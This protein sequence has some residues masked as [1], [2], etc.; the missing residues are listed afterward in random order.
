MAAQGPF[1]WTHRVTYAE[2]TVGNHVYYG[3]YLEWLE[4][5]RGE[6]LRQIGL[7]LAA[8]QAQDL[9]FPVVECRLRYLAPAR[10]DEDVHVQVT[11]TELDRLR[12]S[13]AYQVVKADGTSVLEGATRHVCTSS[14]EKPRRLPEEI[15]Q[16][17]AAHLE[18]TPE[19][20]TRD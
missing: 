4:A 20:E 6:F 11:L 12:V 8:L 3:R 18:E 1:R 17:L 16:K 9:I 14:Q 19:L 13:F 10:Y 7:P 15:R 5:A 2:C